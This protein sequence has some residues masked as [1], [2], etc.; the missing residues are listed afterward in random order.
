M[1]SRAKETRPPGKK[2]AA[3]STWQKK[4]TADLRRK[5]ATKALASRSKELNH[6][7]HERLHFQL[8]EQQSQL[9][10]FVLFALE[11]FA[12]HSSTKCK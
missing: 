10:Q 11:L 3:K 9:N 2:A 5:P 4:K 7:L 6:L 1:K 8:T 12:R